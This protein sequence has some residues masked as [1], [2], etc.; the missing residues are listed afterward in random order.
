M[1]LFYY[2]ASTKELPTGSF[3]QKKTTMKL[4]DYLTDINPSAKEQVSMQALLEKHSPQDLH[5][6]IYETE[7]DAAGL[8]VTGP[9]QGQDTYSVFRFPLVYQ[10]NPEGGA[11]RVSLDMREQYPDSYRNARKCVSELFSYL[12]RNMEPGEEVELYSCWAHGSER[13]LEPRRKEL[14][15][16]ID[17]TTFRVEDEFHWEERQYIVVRR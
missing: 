1:T 6:D 8:Y 15:L 10:V 7:E 17:L 9:M 11:F 14:D 12:Y 4:I 13:F 5:I 3:G 2:M 16:M